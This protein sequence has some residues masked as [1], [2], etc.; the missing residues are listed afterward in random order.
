MRRRPHRARLALA[1]T[2][3]IAVGFPL[4]AFG[5]AANVSLDTVAGKYQGV[6][7]TGGGDLAVKMELRIENG[8]LAGT[9]ETPQGLVT[10]VGSVIT[11]ENVVLKIEMNGAP[12]TITGTYKDGK[13]K[14]TWAI[15]DDSGEF[16]VEKVVGDAKADAPKV[17]A[18]PA[19]TP[20]TKAAA[21]P[22]SDP[23]SGVWDGMAGQGDFTR[24]F[25]MTL[26]LD[27]EKIAGDISSED[28]GGPLGGGSW[29]EGAL[30]LSF[31]MGDMAI[32]MVGALKEGKLVGTLDVS[33][34]MQMPWAAV[35]RT[36]GTVQ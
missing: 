23:I 10:I 22:A 7:T 12:G 32:T 31:S 3:A 36:G 15:G 27:G 18:A 11:G 1:F 17:A 8:A 6:A 16:S 34:Q 13:V 21:V 9:I 30:T 24:A 20:D 5:Q 19:A 29:K 25:T 28:G 4:I 2:A 14:G 33:G 26:K 35:K